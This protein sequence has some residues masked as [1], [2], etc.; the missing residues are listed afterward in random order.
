[1]SILNNITK[2]CFI[3]LI[4]LS[5]SACTNFGKKLGIGVNKTPD[6]FRITK[7][8]PLEIPGGLTLPV[9]Q[10][11][12]QR[13]QE[14]TPQQEAQNVFNT[15]PITDETTNAVATTPTPSD[16]GAFL[17][18]LGATDI[19]PSIRE[20]IAEDYQES[21]AQE[22]PIGLKVLRLGKKVEPKAE[23]IDPKA[24]RERL[25]QNSSQQAE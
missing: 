5:M 1:M 12:A 22:V 16:S 6:E 7:H 20:Q 21:A 25:Q 10:P 14:I 9:P 18:Q 4:G 24:E 17:D 2:I 8:A 11:G 23:T 3:A 13:P 19:N 15:A